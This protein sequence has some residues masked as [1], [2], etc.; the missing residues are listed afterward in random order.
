MWIRP[1]VNRPGIGLV[2]GEMTLGVLYATIMPFRLQTWRLRA[3]DLGN[4]C[5]A[6]G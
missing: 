5:V 6:L 2:C 3:R 1:L 4:L